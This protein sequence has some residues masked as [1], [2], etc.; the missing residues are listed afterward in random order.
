M[1]GPA[2]AVS[3][4]AFLAAAFLAIGLRSMAGSRRERLRELVAGAEA[5]APVA[6]RPVRERRRRGGG[7]I[8]VQGVLLAAATAAGVGLL[9]ALLTASTAIGV[10]ASFSGVLVPRWWRARQKRLRSDA[11]ARQLDGACMVM[12]SALRAGASLAQALGA[13]AAEAAPPLGEEF[14]KAAQ[15]VRLGVPAHEA[16]EEIR[17]RVAVP[18]Y[19]ML[20]VAARIHFA[21]GSNLAEN[22]DRIVERVSERRQLRDALRAATAQERLSATMATAVPFGLV[23]ASRLLIPSYM[24][25]LL[26]VPAG[27]AVFGAALGLM[28]VGWWLVTRISTTLSE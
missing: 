17:R 27:K 24:E 12:A 18:E 15:A 14:S 26:A 28:C 13:V 3:V 7:E 9:A 5:R 1:T 8:E 19:D 20:V 2:G 16:L 11:F 4:L 10:V 6:G 23:V 25:P 22:L 21:T